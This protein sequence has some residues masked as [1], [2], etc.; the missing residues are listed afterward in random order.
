[1]L[2]RSL[3]NRYS[4]SR[5]TAIELGTLPVNKLL[6]KLI[7]LNLDNNL[8]TGSVPSSIAVLLDLEYLFVSGNNGINNGMETICEQ[9]LNIIDQVHANCLFGKVNCSCC[10]TCCGDPLAGGNLTCQI[11]G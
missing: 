1:M 10:T 11:V 6:S 9:Q 7:V 8:F 3:T 4:R 2:F 5:S